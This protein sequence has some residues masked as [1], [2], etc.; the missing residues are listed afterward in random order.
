MAKS[1]SSSRKTTFGKRGR[2]KAVKS[3]NKHNNKS[4]YKKRQGSR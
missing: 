1:V 4:T 2:G 3:Y